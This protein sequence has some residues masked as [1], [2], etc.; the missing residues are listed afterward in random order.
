MSKIEISISAV[1]VSMECESR[2]FEIVVCF[3]L[4]FVTSNKADWVS[5][6]SACSIADLCRRGISFGTA[7]TVVI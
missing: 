3:M 1:V 2:S 5:Y 6:S 7:G 4:V